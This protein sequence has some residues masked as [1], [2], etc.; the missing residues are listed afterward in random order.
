MIIA[1]SPKLG[2]KKINT[3]LCSKCNE[4]EK[5]CKD[6]CQRCYG[7]LHYERTERNRRGCKKHDNHPLLTIKIDKSGYARI[8]TR[9]G[10]G[11]NDWDKYHRYVMEQHLGRKLET[12]ENVHH[13]N[14]NKQDNRL[15]NLELWITKQPKGQRPE[16]LIEYA[17]WI[18][19]TY[20]NE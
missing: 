16:D 11:P 13:K 10:E 1:K 7:G 18:L 19:K 3:G 9:E 12:F 14:G 15:E 5:Y 8:K 4:R 20:N 17:K 6:L 2:R